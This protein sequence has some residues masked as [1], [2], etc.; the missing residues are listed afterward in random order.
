MQ[1]AVYVSPVLGTILWLPYSNW[2]TKVVVGR[3]SAESTGTDNR[4][5]NVKLMVN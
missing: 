5:V 3:F 2:Y 4:L 1:I